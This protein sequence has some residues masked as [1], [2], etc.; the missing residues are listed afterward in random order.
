[1]R[2]EDFQRC[3]IDIQQRFD[4]TALF[5]ADDGDVMQACFENPVPGQDQIAVAAN[6]AFEQ[7][8]VDTLQTRRLFETPD[9]IA[10]AIQGTSCSAISSASSAVST[11]AMR[12]GSK[13]PSR[14]MQSWIL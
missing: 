4:H 13:R 6:A 2:G 5:S 8:P 3:A 12:A 11:E 9:Q 1:M 10:G 14:P 7:R